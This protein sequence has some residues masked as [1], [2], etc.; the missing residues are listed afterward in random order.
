M[1]ITEALNQA[2]TDHVVYF[3]LTAYVESLAWYDTAR[4]YLPP[5]VTRLPICGVMDVGERLSALRCVAAALSGDTAGRRSL[6]QE[7][8]D[9][10]S[11]ASQRLKALRGA[12]PGGVS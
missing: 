11:V 4:W 3:L 6:L 7:A 5:A 1:I 8:L 12:T 2:Y 10:F 9:V